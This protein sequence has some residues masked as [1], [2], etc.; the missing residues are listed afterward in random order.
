MTRCTT[1][2]QALLEKTKL[3]KV[4]P[5]LLKRS[6]EKIK[7]LA[8]KVLDSAE[9][10][11]KQPASENKS[12]TNVDPVKKTTSVSASTNVRASVQANGVTR[13][14][15]I[16]SSTIS[17]LRKP[18]S[19]PSVASK[20]SPAV[21]GKNAI[22]AAKGTQ[23]A[24][25]D[26]KASTLTTSSGNPSTKVKINHVV[27]KPTSLFAGLQSASKKPGTSN[28]A[29]KAAQQTL[30]ADSKKSSDAKPSTPSA[31]PAPAP[32]PGFSFAETMA[33]L[34]KPKEVPS[35]TKSAESGPPE[36]EEEKKKRIR[37]EERRKLRVLF[38]P[39]DSLTE[40]RLFV[41][42]PDEDLGHDDS[43]IRDVGDVRGEGRMLKM[44]KELETDEDEESPPDNEVL[45]P[46]FSPSGEPCLCHHAVSVLMTMYSCG[47]Q[48][49]RIRRTRSKLRYSWR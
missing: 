25:S 14:R 33:N 18:I 37:K 44:H 19:G 17:T 11:S 5:K 22:A 4:F 3:S 35:T 49:Y 12:S 48:R 13:P 38:K 16:T 46:W 10:V 47:L 32:K 1:V 45:F 39:D 41:H 2:D 27:A 23:P 40:I 7:S 43:M 20:Q 24:K 42:D 28:A 31:P 8:Q 29:Q 30:Q 21:S 34:T 9:S 26:G 6:N 15:E 36:T